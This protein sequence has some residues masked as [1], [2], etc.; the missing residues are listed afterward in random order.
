MASGS[1]IAAG[2]RIEVIDAI[3]GFAL[4]GVLWMNL[5]EHVGLILP[6]DALDHLPTAQIDKWVGFASMWLMSGKAQ[7]LFSLLFGFGFA[8]IMSR[9]EANGAPASI[10]L[11]RIAILMVF[12][13]IDVF[14]L[15][16]GDILHAYALMGF[17][18]FFTRNWSTRT[19]LFVGLPMAVLGTITLHVFT[20]LVWNGDR[21]WG[22]Y[23]DEGVAIRGKLFLQADYPAYVA[24]LVRSTI[25][26]WWTKPVILPFL[27]QILGRFLLG[28][29]VFRKGWLG[30]VSAHRDLFLR[31][32]CIALPL[33]LLLEG[34]GA[35]SRVLELGPRWIAALL[36]QP[37]TL[38]LAAGYGSA[39]VLLHLAGRFN[40][41]LSGLGAVGRMALTNYMMQSFFYLF[42]IYGFGVGLL[43]W[44]GA[45]LSL[46]L[47]IAFF[48]FQIAFS[49]W[50]MARYRFG[51]LE[52]VWRSL[53]YGER[54]SMRLG[55]VRA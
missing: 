48:A 16:I 2:D 29:W 35:V 50:W 8:N 27:V 13:L 54:Q 7:A 17:V 34:A 41:L 46:G 4:F 5:Y 12:G 52:W 51:P 22:V 44:L 43:A 53:T 18:L 28:S 11:R 1:P 42:A 32:A 40:T 26:E 21:W 3:R 45:T 10:F 39:I 37:S 6:E 47:A 15:W 33:G 19:L 36:H 25:T 9:L 49:K 20:L 23:I 24:E 30:N 14:M 38:M 55:A 31:I